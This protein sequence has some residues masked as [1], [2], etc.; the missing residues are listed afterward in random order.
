M[1]SIRTLLSE[2]GKPMITHQGYIYTKEKSTANKVIFRCQGRT[3]K[4]KIFRKRDICR[5]PLLF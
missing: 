4:G 2:K 3:C 1:S 5:H